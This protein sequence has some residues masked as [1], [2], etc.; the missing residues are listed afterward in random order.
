M[1]FTRAMLDSAPA[2]SARFLAEPPA[3]VT[4]SA[5]GL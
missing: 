4:L 5:H 1:S 2:R 3:N